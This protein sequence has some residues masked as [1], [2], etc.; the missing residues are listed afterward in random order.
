LGHGVLDA[1]GTLPLT[2]C[3]LGAVG[4]LKQKNDITMLFKD[5]SGHYIEK[6]LKE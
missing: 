3:E 4:D 5:H 2:L 1:L 6:S